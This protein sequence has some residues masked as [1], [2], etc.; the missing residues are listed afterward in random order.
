MTGGEANVK[1]FGQPKWQNLSLQ[2]HHDISL[3]LCRTLLRQER[4]V[5]E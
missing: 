3:L 5:N 4:L 2:I 1:P